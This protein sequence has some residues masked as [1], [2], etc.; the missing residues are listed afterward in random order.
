[1][2][3]LASGTVV[4]TESVFQRVQVVGSNCQ[5]TVEKSRFDMFNDGSIGVQGG[6]ARIENN[7]I[8]NAVEL[9]DSMYVTG[10]APGSTVRFNTFV[11]TSGIASDG[12]ALACDGTP[13]VTSNIFAYNSRHP[14]SP[15]DTCAARYSLFDAT[16]SSEE[17][18]G[19]GNHTADAAAF[20]VDRLRKDFHLGPDS[21][22]RGKAE[23]GLGVVDDIE[24][25]RRPVAA[26]VGAYQGH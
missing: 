21:P 2:D 20:F 24:G 23:P 25:H 7:L 10:V 12:T 16:T 11:N 19:A 18:V 15:A 13:A 3:K 1:M 22:A 9:D 8:V 4:V 5:M 6:F 14:L 26:D 17:A